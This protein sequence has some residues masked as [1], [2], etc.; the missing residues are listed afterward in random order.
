MRR[1]V[2]GLMLLLSMT[3]TTMGGYVYT[4][5]GNAT[6]VLVNIP[7]EPQITLASVNVPPGGGQDS[8]SVVSADVPLVI[9]TGAVNSSVSA[10][11]PTPGITDSQSDIAD[12]S[13]LG[14]LITATGL[15]SSAS[16]FFNGTSGSST[17][18]GLLISGIPVA[19]TGDIGQT[20]DVQVL[21]T[22]V[23]T[24]VLNEQVSS[25]GLDSSTITVNGLR[26]SVLDTALFDP[27]EVVLSQSIAEVGYT[28]VPEPSSLALVCAAVS[29][30]GGVRLARRRNNI[31]SA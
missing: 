31:T 27:L 8:V 24:L 26:L 7:S 13:L 19:V 17:I 3:G 4:Y 9:T 6:G 30:G 21:G 28:A 10:G 12:I 22:T 29:V 25:V 23:A 5:G 2:L 1:A 20:I 11:V 14:G 16:A 18:T 15:T